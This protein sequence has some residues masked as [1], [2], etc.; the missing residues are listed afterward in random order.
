VCC[1]VSD[2]KML[3]GELLVEGVKV[4]MR[5]LKSSM[6]DTVGFLDR[7]IVF[8]MVNHRGIYDIFQI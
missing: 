6:Q 5:L 4:C 1:T 2:G 8:G 3:C 7:K